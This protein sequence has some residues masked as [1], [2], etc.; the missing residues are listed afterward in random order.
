M[1]KT[2]LSK[3]EKMMASVSW[4]RANAHNSREEQNLQKEKQ[5][6]MRQFEAETCQLRAAQNRFEMQYRKTSTTERKTSLVLPP[7][8]EEDSS[9][10]ELLKRRDEKRGSIG[11][12]V[13]LPSLPRLTNSS[14]VI[15]G[16]RPRSISVSSA[17]DTH[18]V[19]STARD[20]HKETAAVQHR[21]RK[22]YAGLPNE[23]DM[24]GHIQ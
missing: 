4:K 12:S 6:L 1:M 5:R 22:S 9:R 24:S 14:F 8:R 18:S 11:T 23:T 19:A 16:A 10:L 17:A 13:S 15:T 2:A 7:L 3:E 21:R 20:S